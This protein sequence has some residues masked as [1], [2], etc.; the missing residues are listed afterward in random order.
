MAL[1]AL[2]ALAAAQETVPAN[3]WRWRATLIREVRVWWG[4]SDSTWAAAQIHQESRWRETARSLYAAGLGQQTPDTVKWLSA[5]Y[6]KELGGGNALNPQW[7][8]RALVAY[9]RRAWVQYDVPNE[10]NRFSFALAAYNGGGGW[11]NRERLKAATMGL[12]PNVWEGNVA[13][14]RVRGIA[15]FTENRDYPRKILG[16]WRPMYRAARW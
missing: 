5:I 2:P 6:P 16:R 8:I 3:A 13:L 1:L 4:W 12:D 11:V 9:M 15:A 7:S 14:V 10:E